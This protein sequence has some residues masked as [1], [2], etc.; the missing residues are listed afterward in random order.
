M[1]A[2]E[3]PKI[4]HCIHCGE[5]KWTIQGFYRIADGECCPNCW[6]DLQR[7]PL[8]PDEAEKLREIKP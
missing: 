2:Q 6:A 5:E 8:T 1:G 4:Y 7:K 3:K